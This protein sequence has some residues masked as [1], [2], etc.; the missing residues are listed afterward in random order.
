MRRWP[1]TVRVYCSDPLASWCPQPDVPDAGDSV[2]AVA[3]DAP[4]PPQPAIAAARSSAAAV[5]AMTLPPPR[6]DPDLVL[7]R[8]RRSHRRYRRSGGPGFR[9]RGLRRSRSVGSHAGH[10]A[11]ASGTS[12]CGHHGASGSLQYAVTVSGHRRSVI[13][14]IPVGYTGKR[15][16]RQPARQRG[17]SPAPRR[18]SAG[19]DATTESADLGDRP[20]PGARSQD[21]GYDWNVPGELHGQREL[22]A[23]DVTF[24]DHPGPRPRQLLPA[25]TWAGS[26][27][28]ALLR[29]PGWPASS[30]ATP[31]RH[32]PRCAPGY[33]PALPREPGSVPGRFRSSPS[34]GTAG[35]PSTFSTGWAAGDWDLLRSQAGRVTN[36]APRARG[37][38]GFTA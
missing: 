21:R 12:G 3:A 13:V 34:S 2:P 38:F 22:P 11:T 37:H 8:V 7:P 5:E 20:L 9:D 36:I 29:R 31:Q 16:L 15:K 10:A 28:P 14:H 32:R 23:G 4:A 1:L 35:P 19:M 25:P 33:R 30:P 26:T 24:L 6:Q 17:A 27:R 18:R